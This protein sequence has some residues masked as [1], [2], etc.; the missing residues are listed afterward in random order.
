[1][2][3]HGQTNLGTA[4]IKA[5]VPAKDLARSLEFY[6]A[7]GFTRD[8]AN[9]ELASL[10]V[11]AAAFLLQAF[12]VKEHAENFMMSLLVE[13]L[14]AWHERATQ[15]AKQFEVHIGQPEDRPWGLRDFTLVDPTGVLWRIAQAPSSR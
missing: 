6:E 3:S 1:M 12:F 8:F 15:V 4:E 5:F 10:R 13:N 2:S 9:D 11:G 7:L 14:A